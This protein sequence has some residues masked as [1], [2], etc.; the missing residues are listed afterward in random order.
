MASEYIENTRERIN[1]LV[2]LIYEYRK[3]K[4]H[5]RDCGGVE[6]L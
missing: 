6:F 5:N 4:Y 3:R 1:K 2:S